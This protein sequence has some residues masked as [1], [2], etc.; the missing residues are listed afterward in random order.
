M[1]SLMVKCLLHCCLA[2]GYLGAMTFLNPEPSLAPASADVLLKKLEQQLEEKMLDRAQKIAKLNGQRWT[3]P[4]LV[5]IGAVFEKWDLPVELGVA[6]RKWENGGITYPMGV[7]LFHRAIM[8]TSIPSLRQPEGAARLCSRAAFWLL[9]EREDIYHEFKR[10]HG[11]RPEQEALI[12]MYPTAYTDFWMEK[13]WQPR[14][15][16]AGM[17][18]YI[19]ATLKKGEARGYAFSSCWGC[20]S[21]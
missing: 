18:E 21:L 9:L 14:L 13:V 20:L 6:I 10:I 2:L 8:A 16:R 4:E 7:T 17:K 1:S 15:N 3:E 19:S 5:R 11:T 12:R